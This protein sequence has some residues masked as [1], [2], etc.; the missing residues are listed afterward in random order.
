MN[1]GCFAVLNQ[2]VEYGVADSC[3]EAAEEEVVL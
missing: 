3:F 2:G 1:V